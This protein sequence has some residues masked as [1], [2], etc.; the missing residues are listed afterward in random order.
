MD[1]VVVNASFIGDA[2]YDLGSDE[3]GHAE[4]MEPEAN[5][6]Y[7]APVRTLA[8]G[9]RTRPLTLY[10]QPPEVPERT[11]D[12][13]RVIEVRHI[14]LW[15]LWGAVVSTAIIAIV[16]LAQSTER[17][18]PTTNG[19]VVQGLSQTSTTSTT[20]TQ[21]TAGTT[22][23]PAQSTT[24]TTGTQAPSCRCPRGT[25]TFA[26]QNPGPCY[27]VANG[28]HG[29]P[30][31]LQNGGLYIRAGPPALA[32]DVLEQ[33]TAVNGLAVHT[34]AELSA[35]RPPV[36]GPDGSGNEGNY[37]PEWYI[38]TYILSDVRAPQC[39]DEITTTT[40]VTGDDE[41][42][43]PSMYLTPYMCI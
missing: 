5:Y 24:T 31:L 38:R 18:I 12:F 20:G 33:A 10:D 15:P 43:P 30:N 23:L 27:A 9:G 17:A 39:S 16:A 1:D 32:G 28:D 19:Q 37:L 7:S 11:Q 8:L 22:F 4:Y 36:Y 40:T 29:T 21:A 42:R 25:I 3:V 26:M 2:L 35:E 34:T 6:H 14:N 41:T 13:V